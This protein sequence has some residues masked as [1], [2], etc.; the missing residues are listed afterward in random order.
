MFKYQ[1]PLSP[2]CDYIEEYLIPERLEEICKD[3]L[4]KRHKTY[5]TRYYETLWEMAEED[6]REERE[7]IYE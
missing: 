6:I 7:E 4:N 5:Y 1:P 3:I 2:S